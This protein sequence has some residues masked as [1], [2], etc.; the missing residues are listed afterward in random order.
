[1]NLIPEYQLL[2]YLLIDVGITKFKTG[3]VRENEVIKT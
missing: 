3:A 2:K 1:M